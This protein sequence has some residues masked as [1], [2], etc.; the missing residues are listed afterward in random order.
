MDDGVKLFF[1]FISVGLQYQE[2]CLNSV[3]NILRLLLAVAALK[4]VYGHMQ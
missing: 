1:A 3:K 4:D 2:K